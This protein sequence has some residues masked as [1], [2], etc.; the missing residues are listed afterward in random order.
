MQAATSPDPQRRYRCTYAPLDRDRVPVACD[1]GVL[2]T[3]HLQA[4]NAEDAQRLAFATVGCPIVLVE[5]LD[6]GAAC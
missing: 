2:P 5:R 1:T 3:L 6:G 4:R